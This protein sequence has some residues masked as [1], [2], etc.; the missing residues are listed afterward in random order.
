MRGWVAVPDEEEFLTGTDE[1]DGVSFPLASGI[2]TGALGRTVI[3]SI[4]FSIAL[5]VSQFVDAWTE[6]VGGLITGVEEFIA[7]STTRIRGVGAEWIE[8]PTDAADGL[9]EVTIG[10]GIAAINGAWSFSLDEFGLF[11]L[12]VA[13]GAVVATAWVANELIGVGREVL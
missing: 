3:G 1:A 8:I 7:G 10:A 12:P 2:D 4:A 9:I 11:A 6:A 5:G 13:I